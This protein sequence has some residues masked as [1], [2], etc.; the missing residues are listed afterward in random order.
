MKKKNGAWKKSPWTI[1]IGT[2]IFSFFLTLLYDL[3]KNKPILSSIWE[4]LKWLGNVIWH[5]L[6]FDIKVWWLLL[7][8]VLI[9]FVILLYSKFEKN[10]TSVQESNNYTEDRIKG[11]RWT[12]RWEFS[13]SQ[14]AWILSD[15]KSHCPE[16]NTP[17]IDQTVSYETYFECPR[18][19][20]H[21]SKPNDEKFKVSNIIIDNINRKKNKNNP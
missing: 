4:I 18:C 11:M 5:I 2:A 3:I 7:F 15:L 12:W 8:V 20:Y 10:D 19:D 16:C 21:V 14:K 13:A 1:G 9:V 6:N 17:M